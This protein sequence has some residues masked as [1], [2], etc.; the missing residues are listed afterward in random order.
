MAQFFALNSRENCT[1]LSRK[2]PARSNIRYILVTLETSHLYLA[3]GAR[4]EDIVKKYGEINNWDVSKVTRMSYMFEDAESFNQPLNNWN[5]SKV[6]DMGGRI[7]MRLGLGL[8]LG[9]SRVNFAT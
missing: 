4:K 7:R 5:V 6:K 2:D 1:A 9:E 3:G 8:G